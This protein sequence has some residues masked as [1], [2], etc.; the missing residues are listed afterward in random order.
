[1]NIFTLP[2]KILIVR[3]KYGL[4]NQLLSISKGITFALISN[5]DIYFDNFQVDYKDENNIM[6]FYEVIDI[7]YL[8]K[9]INDKNLNIK[10]YKKIDNKEE[11]IKPITYSDKNISY[12]KDFTSIL[13]NENNNMQFYL[14]IDNPISSDFPPGYDDLIEYINLNIQ[15]HGKFIYIA[16]NI[17]K[18]L[19]LR[20]Y[21]CVHLRLEDDALNFL[22]NYQEKIDNIKNIDALTIDTNRFSIENINKICIEKYLNLFDILKKDGKQIYICSSLGVNNNINNEFYK[23]IKKKYNLI[24]KNDIILNF[25]NCFIEIFPSNQNNLNE[26]LDLNIRELFGIIDFIIAK[27]G[28]TFTG[29][30][31]SSF[32]IY[33]DKHYKH[34]NKFT[35]L[36]DIFKSIYT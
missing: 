23:E 28:N 8:Q 18:K 30:D 6:P 3:P 33:L 32:S 26:N 5:R 9:K 27:E 34:Y 36:L 19:N 12:I 13:L 24:D 10:I 1:M 4:C 7:E 35:Y 22:K 14:D 15:F 16:K 25:E 21:N 20:N 17:K 11:W 29:C 2:K 31:W